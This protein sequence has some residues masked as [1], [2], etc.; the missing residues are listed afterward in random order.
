MLFTLFW[1]TFLA[2]LWDCNCSG[3]CSFI[4]IVF[5]IFDLHLDTL[6]IDTLSRA[7]RNAFEVV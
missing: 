2:S 4:H 5:T 7:R 1:L 6:P 3:Y